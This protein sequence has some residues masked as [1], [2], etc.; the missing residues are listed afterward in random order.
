MDR[1]WRIC[2]CW[3]VPWTAWWWLITFGTILKALNIMD[4]PFTN[5]GDIAT[6]RNY[7]NWNAL[8]GKL[9]LWI[10]RAL[11]LDNEDKGMYEGGCT[12]LPIPTVSALTNWTRWSDIWMLIGVPRRSSCHLQSRRC[13][14]RV[15]WWKGL[16]RMRLSI[17]IWNWR[18]CPRRRRRRRIRSLLTPARATVCYTEISCILIIPFFNL[19]VV[20]LWCCP[21]F[22]SFKFHTISGGL[23]VGILCFFSISKF[24][25]LEIYHFWYNVSDQIMYRESPH[26]IPWVGSCRS[27]HSEVTMLYFVCATFHI[28]NCPLSSFSHFH[29][30]Q[31]DPTRWRACRQWAMKKWASTLWATK[32]VISWIFIY[33]TS[34]RLLLSPKTPSPIL[35]TSISECCPLA[36]RVPSR[37]ESWECL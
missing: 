36:N 28:S 23:R 37:L 2:R 27:L 9:W 31:R 14:Q 17:S 18:I 8:C 33:L 24:E 4:C 5:I 7:P 16:K 3:T 22:D 35:A 6:T 19:I 32:T 1:I 13:P 30:V 26:C 15:I 20:L 25:S 34:P 21:F 12:V 11:S 29:L 10:P